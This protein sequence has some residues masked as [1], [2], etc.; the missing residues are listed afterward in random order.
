MMQLLFA[1][2]LAAYTCVPI[3]GG[4]LYRIRGG[5][6]PDPSRSFPAWGNTVLTHVG[7]KGQGL[8]GVV[9]TPWIFLSFV[10]DRTRFP[11]YVDLVL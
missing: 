7:D 6:R 9:V 11:L 8:A 5:W 1:L 3:C 4:L 10:A 2:T